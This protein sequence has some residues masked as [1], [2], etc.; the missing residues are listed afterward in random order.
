MQSGSK[1]LERIQ[2]A[3]ATH[4]FFPT[5]PSSKHKGKK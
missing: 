3:A 5:G 2:A 1:L 4:I